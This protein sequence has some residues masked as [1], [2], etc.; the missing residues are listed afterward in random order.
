MR[1]RPSAKWLVAILAGIAP[2]A[3]HGCASPVSSASPASHA[4]YVPPDYLAAVLRVN[5]P[6]YTGGLT[7]E[8]RGIADRI[9]AA[10]L[11]R[12][13]ADCGNPN[14]NAGILV[15]L[16]KDAANKELPSLDG[17]DP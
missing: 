17:I 2:S 13:Y 6:N 14:P 3:L 4:P 12:Y 16:G 10:L 7:R 1:R 5:T 8:D 15:G 9:Q 11:S